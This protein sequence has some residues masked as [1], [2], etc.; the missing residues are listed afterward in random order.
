MNSSDEEFAITL[1][2]KNYKCKCTLFFRYGIT[3]HDM[4]LTNGIKII[5]PIVIVCNLN[6]QNQQII[7]TFRTLDSKILCNDVKEDSFLTF[8]DPI[9]WKNI[10]ICPILGRQISKLL[11]IHSPSRNLTLKCLIGICSH[12]SR[13]NDSSI[14]GKDIFHIFHLLDLGNQLIDNFLKFYFALKPLTST[15]GVNCLYLDSSSPISQGSQKGL[16]KFEKQRKIQ[17]LYSLID[18]QS[19][20][21]IIVDSK[22]EKTCNDFLFL[23]TKV[24]ND[25]NVLILSSKLSKCVIENVFLKLNKFSLMQ[26]II[27]QQPSIVYECIRKM[28][29]YDKHSIN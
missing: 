1:F 15:N 11:H 28:F 18:S 20:H 6:A 7:R 14:I 27:K 5:S 2:V 16:S 24:C 21:L 25:Q 17:E 10:T 26:L 19:I 13:S 9:V 12:H 4:F 3:Y 8:H 29:L 22:L 23:L